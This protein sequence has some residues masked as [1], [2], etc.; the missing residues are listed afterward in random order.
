[1]LKIGINLLWVRPNKNG[2]TE[3][4]IRN[5]LDGLSDY[6][7]EEQQYYLYVSNDNAVSFDK[8]F[9]NRHFIKRLCN[10]NTASQRN[11]IFWENSH[12]SKLGLMDKLD[13]WFMPVYS[14]PFFMSKKIPV[15]TVI[16][17]IQGMH[18][19]E[20]FSW[21]RNLFFRLSW[22]WDCKTSARII[23]ISNF[24][25]EDILKHYRISEDT[26]K[27]IYN[28]IITNQTNYDFS[29]L[30]EKF[31]I[32]DR[33]YYYTVSS[34]AKHKNLITLL[35]AMKK[36]KEMERKHKLL[37][38][39]VKVNAGDEIEQFVKDNSLEDVVIF[40]GFISNEERD[41]LYDHC[42]CFLFASVF[43]GFG[44]PPIEAMRRGV[45]VITTKETSLYE[46]TEGKANYVQ[47]PFDEDEWGDVMIKSFINKRYEFKN[48][49]LERITKEYAVEF[50]TAINDD[51][52]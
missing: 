5:L 6:A 27:V 52:K 16:H 31:A 17:D 9:Q 12:L 3:S 46:V 28:P 32:K 36:L 43:E 20:Y 14:R 30:E 34:L 44:M 18:Y 37:I 2:G 19:P 49:N 22:W 24:C 25:K 7:P 50:S 4:Y 33:E 8:Y 23:T 42:K 40:T 26:I 21:G 1:M 35:K 45:P 48:Y 29:K 11:R 47:N 51:E 39:G 41:S 38:S 13:V 10:V 15:I